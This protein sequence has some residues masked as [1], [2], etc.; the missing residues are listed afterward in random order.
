MDVKRICALILAVLMEGIAGHGGVGSNV[1]AVAA[2]P[3]GGATVDSQDATVAED[4]G[5]ASGEVSQ[6]SLGRRRST[7]TSPTMR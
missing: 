5:E 3:S 1:A 4:F 7:G 2:D 6:A